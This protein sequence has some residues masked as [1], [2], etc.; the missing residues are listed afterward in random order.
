MSKLIQIAA[1]EIGQEELSGSTHNPRIIQYA[2]E[3]GIK[4]I[5]KDEVA[6]CSTFVNWVAFKCD[7]KRTNRA[8]ARSWLSVGKNV[9]SSPEPGDIVIF[10]RE[11]PQSWKGH[12]GFFLG[13]SQNQS[14]VYCL[15][16]N[17]GNAV[18]ISAY[19]S[20][21]ILG[22]RRLVTNQ[23]IDLPEG[24]FKLGDSGEKIKN[25]QQAL[26]TAGFPCGTVD[27]FFGNKTEEAVKNLQS[28]SGS[29]KI[30]GVF[31]GQTKNYLLEILQN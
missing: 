7:L 3:S 4:G 26:N 23:M 28:A 13:Y 24:F 16:G 18:S 29:L 9:N 19:P 11:S 1:A 6:W 25:L 21:T 12:V 5:S 15:G 10:W 14:R 20:D 30:D 22:F 31:G 8:N 27:G 17:Q 2:E